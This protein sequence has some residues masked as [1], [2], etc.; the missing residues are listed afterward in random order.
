MKRDCR[1][2]VR[3]CGGVRGTFGENERAGGA[4]VEA[5]ESRVLLAGTPIISE[6]MASNSLTR[7]VDGDTSDWIEI[8]NP[9]ASPLSLDGYYLSDDPGGVDRWRLPGQMIPAG[10]YLVVFASGKDRA[11]VGQ[12]LHTDFRSEERRGGK[13]CRCRA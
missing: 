10:G 5:L 8:H 4:G 9:L 7:D 1:R 6:F 12:Q 2:A 11:V 3:G 13:E